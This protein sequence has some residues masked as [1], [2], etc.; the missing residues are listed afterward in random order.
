MAI[1]LTLLAPASAR[2]DPSTA[3]VLLQVR[4]GRWQAAE[5]RTRDE[6]RVMGLHVA[7]VPDRRGQDIA[8]T[9]REHGARAAIR[10]HRHGDIGDAQV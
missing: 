2:A 5:D 8:E 7:E 10:M 9:M 4:D 3:V 1:A 6:L